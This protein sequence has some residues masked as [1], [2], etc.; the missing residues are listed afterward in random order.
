MTKKII[1][2]M[3]VFF[4]LLVIFSPVKAQ[5]STSLAYRERFV[6]QSVRTVFSA[7][8]TYQ[9]TIGAGQFATLPELRQAGLIDAVLASGEKYGYVFVL[10]R[11]HT[12]STSL[13]KFKLTATPRSYPKT[14]RRSFYIDETGDMR[15]ANKMGA[16]ANADDPVLD[17]CASFGI[18][19]NERC[20]IYDL[21]TLLIAE[22]THSATVGNGNYGSLTDLFQ[23]G[24]INARLAAGTT[25]GYNFTV[26]HL[27]QSPG[28]PAFF[29]LR[30]VPVNYGT[31]GIRSFYLDVD[32]I[33][34]GADRQGQPADQN[35]PPILN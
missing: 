16:A 30:A 11:T 10:T 6:L 20:V 28:S 33:L 22:L 34:R 19:F 7:Q 2:A 17:D 32:G 23:A 15:G 4:A 12:S 14:G 1:F 13:A 3:A 27:P 9:S 21:R 18:F 26:F 29:S 5:T 25:R 31:D 8:I 24:L 35:D